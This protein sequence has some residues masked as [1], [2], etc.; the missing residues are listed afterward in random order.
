M[1]TC[2][3]LNGDGNWKSKLDLLRYNFIYQV[4][5]LS[6]SLRN[7]KFQKILNNHSVNPNVIPKIPAVVT[8]FSQNYL[9]RAEAVQFTVIG[10]LTLTIDFSFLSIGAPTTNSTT[11]REFSTSNSKK[12]IYG[13]YDH[14]HHLTNIYTHRFR[15][16]FKL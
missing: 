11:A 12:K 5:Q 6:L 2:G 3:V 14:H 4:L 15:Y 13:N 8:K 7:Y 16:N 9:S 10:L 1:G